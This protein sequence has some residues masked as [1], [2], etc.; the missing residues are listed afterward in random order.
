MLKKLVCGEASKVRWG[1]IDG[2]RQSLDNGVMR[3][4][5]PAA[6]FGMANCA[7]ALL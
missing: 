7:M 3:V 1:C 2:P 6:G 5:H 4:N